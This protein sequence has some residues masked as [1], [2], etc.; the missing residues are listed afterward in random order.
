MST[1]D[2]I[3]EY[4]NRQVENPPENLTLDTKLDTIGVD[5]LAMLELMFELEEKY[6]IQLPDNAPT[7]DTIGQLVEL[8]DKYKPASPQ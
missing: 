6:N 7:P 4:I 3:K 8:F 2:L 5:S 1:L